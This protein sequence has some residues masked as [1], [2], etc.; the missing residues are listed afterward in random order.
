MSRHQIT[1][2][3]NHFE[4]ESALPVSSQELLN[5][6]IQ[7]LD[8]AHAPYSGFHVGAALRLANGQIL[9]G[10]NQE[11]AAYPSGLCAERTVVYY[12]GNAFP[13]VKM[14]EIVV[15][16]RKAGDTQLV[17]ACPCGACRQAILEYEERQGSPIRL[18]FKQLDK[19][20]L[21]LDSVA[22]S[23]P[24]KFGADSLGI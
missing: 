21:G 7:A 17:P 24:F 12:A 3:F 19:G 2:T 16:A 13:K 22:D 4:S 18:I 14:E 15:V 5:A 23:L 1:L 10:S 11:N 6:A 9:L 8:Q 20:F